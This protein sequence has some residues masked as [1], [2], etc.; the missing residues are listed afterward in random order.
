MLSKKLSKYVVI[1]L[2]E[3]RELRLKELIPIIMRVA[4][5]TF[6]KYESPKFHKK[7]FKTRVQSALYRL[8]QEGLLERTSWGQWILTNSPEN[9]NIQKPE[10]VGLSLN[11]HTDLQKPRMLRKT[12]NKNCYGYPTE[13]CEVGCPIRANCQQ[14]V[15]RNLERLSEELEN[16]KKKPRDLYWAACMQCQKATGQSSLVWVPASGVYHL[17]CWLKD[18]RRS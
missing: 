3:K 6:S 9:E 5:I 13:G 16:T 4:N 10:E 2:K 12:I 15:R 1:A 18:K 11:L 17:K 14:E 8:E 7:K